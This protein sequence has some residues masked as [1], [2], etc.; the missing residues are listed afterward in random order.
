MVRNQ[1][2]QPLRKLPRMLRGSRLWFVAVAIS[3]VS[4]AGCIDESAELPASTNASEQDLL[5]GFRFGN[6]CTPQKTEFL[7]TATRYGRT[8]AATR[9]F[10]QCVE[11]V[12]TAQTIDT[13]GG[14]AGGPYGQCNGDPFWGSPLTAQINAVLDAA[15]SGNDMMLYCT[16]GRGNA[17]A[18]IGDYFRTDTETLNFTT[19]LD[20]VLDLPFTAG[21]RYHQAA[22]TIWHEM[23]HQHGYNHGIAPDYER[24]P[25][26]TARENAMQCGRAG[27]PTW[28]YQWNTVPYLVGSCVSHVINESTSVC[29]NV[30]TCGPGMLRLVTGFGSQGCECVADPNGVITRPSNAFVHVAQSWNTGSGMTTLSHPL[31]DSNP[32]AIVHIQHLFKAP[33]NPAA[34]AGNG[35]IP[36]YNYS[37]GRWV[38]QNRRG[39]AMPDGT[40]FVVRIGRGMVHRTSTTN[41]VNHM[42]TIDHPLANGNP[43]AMLTVT[44]APYARAFNGVI[45]DHPIGVYFN[46]VIQRWQ[47]YNQDWAPMPLNTGFYVDVETERNRGLH[48]SHVATVE[49]IDRHMTRLSSPFLNGNPNA[50]FIAT[51]NWRTSVYN[52]NQYGIYYDGAYWWI[53][54]EAN[55]QPGS[56][57]PVNAGFDIEILRTEVQRWM[58]VPES[59]VGADTGISLLPTDRL[60]IH[61]SSQIWSGTWLTPKIGPDGESGLPYN[62]RFPLLSAPR[63]SLLGKVASEEYFFIG[64]DLS[65]GG[66]AGY[67]R[68]LSLLVNDDWHGNGDGFFEAEVRVFR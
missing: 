41:I 11:R 29:G 6:D 36:F 56:A 48:F 33:G 40:A 17:S 22:A 49:T 31:L 66:S 57:M 7:T 65:R 45:N 64:R 39:A 37:I 5:G 68:Q 19:W 26:R 59:A 67:G 51:P 53:Y 24:D 3:T 10:E 52:T 54:N 32:N 16:G 25:E 30:E 15:R 44:A 38:I 58:R 47:I 27:D 2:S 42:T 12:M 61:A 55:G 43:R 28:H 62:D 34:Y 60:R 4:L 8:V 35:A 20:S 63:F 1:E 23:M 13:V 9:A 18:G 14:S 50:M 46:S 21:D